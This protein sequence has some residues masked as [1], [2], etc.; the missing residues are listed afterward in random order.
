M[1]RA[2]VPNAEV[3]ETIGISGHIASALCV[4]KDVA[5][6]IAGVDVPVLNV[7]PIDI[8]WT[9]ITREKVGRE[10]VMCLGRGSTWEE[11][12]FRMAQDY[13]ITKE[14]LLCNTTI[15][16]KITEGYGEEWEQEVRRD[17]R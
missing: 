1:V 15:T 6:T 8:V 9:E 14:C 16:E 11:D 12:V 10:Y 17:I 2:Y 4:G 5:Q 7:T 3:Q 13:Q